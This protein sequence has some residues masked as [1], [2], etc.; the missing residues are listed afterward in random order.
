MHNPFIVLYYRSDALDGD[1]LRAELSAMS[2]EELVEALS[3]FGLS[4]Q[5]GRGERAASASCSCA[6]LLG[7]L[8]KGCTCVLGCLVRAALFNFAGRQV[9]FGGATGGVHGGRHGQVGGTMCGSP[10]RGEMG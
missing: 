3:S 6:M 7:C 9:R 8:T 10:W 4:V 1:S 5:V 2:S